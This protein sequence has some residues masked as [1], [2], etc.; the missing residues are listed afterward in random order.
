MEVVYIGHYWADI[1][2][3]VNW[4][5][6]CCKLYKVNA[7]ILP[8]L[9]AWFLVAATFDRTIA[10]TFPH[11]VKL[12]ITRRRTVI[13]IIVMT[14]LSGEYLYIIAYNKLIDRCSDKTTVR[15]DCQLMLH[16]KIEIEIDCFQFYSIS[17]YTL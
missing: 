11:K 10:V 3:P 15:Y 14:V 1:L 5:N 2:W 12:W 13:A 7:Y 8:Q 16:I 17:F 9:S 4:V 6:I